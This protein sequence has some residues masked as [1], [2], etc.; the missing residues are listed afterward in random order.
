MIFQSA[1]LTDAQTGALQTSILI[2]KDCTFSQSLNQDPFFIF[3]H[4]GNLI[5]AITV[6]S[7]L[8]DNIFS[9]RFK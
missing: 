2:I 3:V 1:D 9:Q 4:A 5:K 7:D 8:N 6:L